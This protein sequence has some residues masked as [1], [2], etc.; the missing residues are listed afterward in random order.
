M[1][2]LEAVQ[3]RDKLRQDPTIALKLASR[4]VQE[5]AKDPQCAACKM[6]LLGTDKDSVVDHFSFYHTDD[7]TKLFKDEN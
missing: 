6:Y 7:I 2:F 5:R 3:A 1:S 4:Y